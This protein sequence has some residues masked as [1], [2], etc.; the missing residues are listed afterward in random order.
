M[1][2]KKIQTNKQNATIANKQTSKEK[3]NKQDTTITNNNP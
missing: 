2:T 1:E 3:T